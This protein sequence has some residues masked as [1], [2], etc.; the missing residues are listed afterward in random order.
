MEHDLKVRTERVDDIP[1]LLAQ[2]QKM[3]VAETLDN[4]L[5]RHGNRRGLSVGDL[6]AVWL[7]FIVSEGDHRMNQ[8][9]AWAEERGE[10]LG[11]CLGHEVEAADC[12]IARLGRVLEQ[13]SDDEVWEAYEAEL[14]GTTLRAYDLASERVRV[15]TTTAS[16]YG[17]VDGEGMLRFGHSKDRRPD[18]PQLKVGL[19]V[20]DPLGM[21]LATEVVAGN[22]ADDPMYLPAIA[23]LRQSLSRSGVLYVGDSKLGSLGNRAGIASEGDY[24]LC[25]LSKVQLP[26]EQLLAYLQPYLKAQEV[27]GEVFAQGGLTEV[28]RSDSEGKTTT[29]GYAFEVNEPKSVAVDAADGGERGNGEEVGW[30]E[31]RIVSYSLSHAKAERTRLETRVQAA[32]RALAGLTESKQGKHLPKSREELHEAVTEVLSRHRVVG[33]LRFS[34]R[35]RQQQRQVRAYGSQPA[36]TETSTTLSLTVSR[37]EAALT[38]LNHTL[39]WRVLVTNQP[40]AQLPLSQVVLVYR[41]QHRVESSIA[42]LKGR[43][44]SLTPMFLQREDHIK[45]LVRLLSVA[46]RVLTL[47][48]F[49]VRDALQREGDTLQ[50][51]YSGQ[52]K[53]TSK[54]PRAETLLRAFKGISLSIV[55]LGKKVMRHISELSTPQQRILELLGFP[56]SLYSRLASDL[57]GNVGT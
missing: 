11:G 56:K 48:E 15:D 45:G 9:E 12:H 13:L 54:R 27:G 5:V 29:I 32:E 41:D 44:L 30:S 55:T 8:L 18:L 10:A 7:A 24:Y 43:P 28:V 23:R 4:Q 20:L 38:R 49:V 17:E 34:I 3:K 22:K 46:L 1:I 47:T 6:M 36:R 35:E 50:G 40:A 31:R 37:D 33:L 21:P 42:R 26:P 16:Y 14:N 57:P 39:G 51:L 2:L 52:A 19:G 25:P 53:R